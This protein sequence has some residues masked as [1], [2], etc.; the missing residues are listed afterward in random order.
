MAEMSRGPKQPEVPD[1]DASA[2]ASQTSLSGMENPLLSDEG[3]ISFDRIRI[4]HIPFAIRELIRRGEKR[5]AEITGFQGR[6]TFENTVIAIDRLPCRLEEAWRVTR[7]LMDTVNSPDLEEAIK[8]VEQDYSRFLSSVR[9]SSGLWTALKEYSAGPESASL[10]PLRR[11]ALGRI[12]MKFKL[13]GVDLDGA[14]K[15]LLM[16]IDARLA[17]LET[18]FKANLDRAS[19]Q[20]MIILGQAPPGVPQNALDAARSKAAEKGLA[21]KFLFTAEES[22][23]DAVMSFAEDAKLRQRMFE[24]FHARGFGG[25]F[26]N[27]PVAAEELE[28]R[29]RKAEILKQAGISGCE[30]FADFQICLRMGGNARKVRSLLEEIARRAR[31]AFEREKKELT[32]F[33]REM[34]HNPAAEMNPWDV[35]Y[36]A[37]KLRSRRFGFDESG[38]Q[39]YFPLE[40][41]LAGLFE[42]AGRLYGLCI[43]P[44]A[45]LAGWHE[46]VR[47]YDVLDNGGKI[48]GSFYMDPYA[49]EGSKSEGAWMTTLHQPFAQAEGQ[50]EGKDRYLGL[51]A[52]NFARPFPGSPTL[53]K[54]RELET[55]FHEFGHLIHSLFVRSPF[56]CLDDLPRDAVELPSQ[57]FE[58]W[59]WDEDILRSLS[60]HHGKE[61]CALPHELFEKMRAA[62]NFQRATNTIMHLT[63]FGL[64]D[65]ALHTEYTR[66]TDGDLAAF[67]RSFLKDFAPAGVEPYQ[68]RIHR[69]SHLFTGEYAAGY[70]SYIWALVL[71]CD[72]FGRFESEGLLNRQTGDEFRKCILSRGDTVDAL[73]AYNEFL[74]RPPETPP[75]IDALCKTYGLTR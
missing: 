62:R 72:A 26:D 8:A 52:F 9:L 23:Y 46:D 64:L 16:D 48:L 18:C 5:A 32:E 41:A 53:L 35:A 50:T 40:K 28:L 65:L 25:P 4:E 14:N 30:S 19:A 10:D 56:A 42:V 17:A 54:H 71:A 59:T 38:L 58:N 13:A 47:A 44:N 74:R 27:L 33:K 49:R 22:S 36:Y 24:A 37:E 60:A 31:A 68:I 67:G 29:R 43:R 15:K 21:G 61:D 7:T 66:Q 12:M 1:L 39:R 70:Y 45:Q 20:A 73:H 11:R 63:G 3:F 34:E 51:I 6:R 75:N 69:F 57:I 2:V 55:L